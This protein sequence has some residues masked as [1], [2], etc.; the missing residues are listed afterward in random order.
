[1]SAEVVARPYQVKVVLAPPTSEPYVVGKVPGKPEKVRVEVLTAPTPL[2]PVDVSKFPAEGF[3]VVERPYHVTVELLP[4]TRAPSVP[5]PLKGPLNAREVVA[6]LC[7]GLV[8]L[9]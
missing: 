4:P 9:P 1:M 2:A 7:T 3:E 8:P 6:T 5:M